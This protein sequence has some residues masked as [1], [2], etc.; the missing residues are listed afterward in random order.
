[1]LLCLVLGGCGI[2]GGQDVGQRTAKGGSGILI[3]VDELDQITKSFA[4]RYVLLLANACDELKKGSASREEKRIAHRLKVT[5]ATAAFDAATGP[6]PV[7]QLVDLAVGIRL[8]KVV[9]V[10]ERQGDRIFGAGRADT[11]DEALVTADREIWE[12]CT[13][14]MR[15]EQSHALQEAISQWR[16]AN[17]QLQWVSDV[18]FDVVAGKEG[19][20]LIAGITKSLSPASGSVTDSVGQARLLGQRA[21]YFLKRLPRILDWQVEDA[22]ENALSTPE[23]ASVVKGASQTLES[24]AT[25][26]AR[27]DALL[28]AS[29]EEEGAPVDPK[30]H[31]IHQLLSE[32]KALAVA[33][34]EAATAIGGARPEPPKKDVPSERVDKD[35]VQKDKGSGK[36]FDIKDYT[37][38]GAQFAQTIHETTELLRE[39][40]GSLESGPA[41]RRAEEFMRS[42]A[43]IIAR[44]RKNAINQAASRLAQILIL[45][46]L[47]VSLYTTLLLW[48]GRRWRG[49]APGSKR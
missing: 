4:D 8:Q 29:P 45:A 7:K 31:E 11:L 3:T 2:S 38:A 48:L 46:A 42:T 22:L 37:Q 23:A 30:L 41:V 28:A 12:L 25:L 35:A 19:E 13:R 26:L 15:P 27:L 5:G 32:G 9:W 14:A 10:D 47:L 18:R 40:R 39:A 6:D 36:P 24:A 34:R 16:R 49:D 17:P 33:V 1:M 43:G 21:F 44:E 20:T